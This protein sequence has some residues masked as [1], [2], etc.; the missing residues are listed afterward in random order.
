MRKYP[1]MLRKHAKK[2]RRR[3]ERWGSLYLF[4]LVVETKMFFDGLV[5][6]Q[7]KLKPHLLPWYRSICAL[8]NV[9]A[10]CYVDVL[11]A[12]HKLQ[13]DVWPSVVEYTSNLMNAV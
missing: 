9:C 8:V 3:L 4:I 6:K 7:P 11:D 12:L 5:S 13:R 2:M 1:R 10:H